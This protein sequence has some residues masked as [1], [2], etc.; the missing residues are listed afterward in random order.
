MARRAALTMPSP[1]FLSAY[2]SGAALHTPN[3]SW[4]LD[5]QIK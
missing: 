2:A 5:M 3:N 1:Y 4:A